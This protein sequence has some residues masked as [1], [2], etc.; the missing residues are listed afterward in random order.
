MR[1][2]STPTRLE[3]HRLKYQ[4]AGRRG[5]LLRVEQLEKVEKRMLQE[6]LLKDV[7]VKRIDFTGDMDEQ[8]Y[9]E[10]QCGV[11]AEYGV[12]CP[13][14]RYSQK[15]AHHPGHAGEPVKECGVCGCII[16]PGGWREELRIKV[17]K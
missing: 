1:P 13:H 14:P 15:N 16:F 6:E 10:V 11:F 7:R 12:M 17:E 8:I 5:Q 9:D 4:Q 2:R 3:S